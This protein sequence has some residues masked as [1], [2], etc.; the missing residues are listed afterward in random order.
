[1]PADSFG[2]RDDR[3]VHKNC[4][5]LIQDGKETKFLQTGELIQIGRA[6]KVVEGP[7]AGPGGVDPTSGTAVAGDP[8][9]VTDDI[10]EFVAQL[11]AL[12]KSVPMI[13]ADKQAGWAK[14]L[15]DSLANAAESGADGN[16]SHARLKQL[17]ETFSAAPQNPL[18]PY[19][20]FRLIGAEN[21]M[22]IK[23]AVTGPQI[24]EAQEK[25]RAALEGFVNAYPKSE[26]AG[27]AI[28]RLAMSYEFLGKVGEAKARTWCEHLFKNYAGH[29][30]AAKAAGILKRLDCEGKPL[31]L[32]GTNLATGQPFTMQQLSG[33]AA[34][35]YY[36]ASWSDSLAAD[37]K[38]LKELAASYGPKGL[39][40]VCISLDDK[41]ETAG[42]SIQ[43][44]GLPGIHLHAPGGIEASPFAASYGILV[45]PQIFEIG[46]DGKIA[47][48]NGEMLTLEDDVKKL[49]Q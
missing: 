31:E 48:R 8:P 22:L 45:V 24:Q 40:I 29:H 13:A 2:G 35:V 14:L 10:R 42:Q 47:K 6:W 7:T 27:E 34:I 39:E 21:G 19:A 44:L 38:K 4:T 3:I 26:D 9:I 43:K 46:K 28:M 41:A 16:P 11:D 25:N 20:A 5:I 1:T 37:A 32:A 36:W 49:T 33:K 18:G 12:D 17:K 30:H 15:I 23:K